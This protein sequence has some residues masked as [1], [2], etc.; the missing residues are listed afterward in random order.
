MKVE[1]FFKQA[2]KDYLSVRPP[3]RV[4]LYGWLELTERLEKKK[5][6]K[7]AVV[8]VLLRPA[9]AVALGIMLFIGLSGGIV[10]AAK[11]SLPGEALYPV[12]RTYENIASSITGS[13]EMKLE[14]RAQEIII[15][16]QRE[17]QD[18]EKLKETVIEYQATV[19][20]F[21]E[22]VKEEK[23]E[24]LKQNLRRQRDEFKRIYD[25]S[26]SKEEIKKAIEA[27]EEEW[28]D[29]KDNFER[30]SGTQDWNLEDNN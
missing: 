22:E 25:R 12:K 30:N 7:D 27:A 10:Y 4:S 8:W 23:K 18:S 16:S 24:E 26:R 14:G 6:L 17:E 21:K 20:R 13:S 11:N 19:A 1:E 28:E 2:K 3:E 29:Q 5:S 15:L 9:F